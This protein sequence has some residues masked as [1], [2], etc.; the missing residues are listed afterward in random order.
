M[1]FRGEMISAE[2]SNRVLT[3]WAG[4]PELVRVEELLE[5]LRLDVL[6]GLEAGFFIKAKTDFT[7]GFVTGD[8]IPHSNT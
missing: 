6:G 1:I 5:G 2:G 4:F 8:S 7:K 3:F